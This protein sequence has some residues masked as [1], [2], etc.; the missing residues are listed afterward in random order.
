[1]SRHDWVGNVIY[2]K[3]C[4]RFNL[5][6]LPN[7]IYTNQNLSYKMKFSVTLGESTWNNPARK[8]RVVLISKEKR[9]CHRIVNERK[10]KE[11]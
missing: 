4:K 8:P 7:C 3:L 9:P 10:W 1:M 5:I 6:I 11:R 2:W